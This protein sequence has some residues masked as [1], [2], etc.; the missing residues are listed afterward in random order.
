MGAGDLHHYSV[1]RPRGEVDEEAP[2]PLA[3]GVNSC[4]VDAVG[5]YRY[6]GIVDWLALGIPQSALQARTCLEGVI[7]P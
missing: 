1:K 5:E 2:V 3:R 4:L 6:L 7:V